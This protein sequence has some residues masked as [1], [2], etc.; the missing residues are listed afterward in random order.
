M[1]ALHQRLGAVEQRSGVSARLI[2]DTIPDLPASTE[3]CLYRIACEAL[4]NTLKHAA[5]TEVKIYLSMSQGTVILEI[6]DNS[7]GFP[8]PSSSAQGGLGLVSMRERAAKLGGSLHITSAPGQGAKIQ[9]T[10]PL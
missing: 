9:A 10:F 3:E 2:T 8:S 7:Q 4:N 6:T 5:A 1:G